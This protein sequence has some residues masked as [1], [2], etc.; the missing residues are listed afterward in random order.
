MIL[1]LDEVDL[2]SDRERNKDLLYLLS[3]SEKQYMLILLSNNPGFFEKI[4]ASA[5]SS[6]QLERVFFRNY[7][8]LEIADILRMRCEEAGCRSREDELVQ[9]ASLTYKDD[10]GDVRVALK[11]LLYLLMG[12]YPSVQKCFG[13]ARRDLYSDL[14]EDQSDAVLMILKAATDSR[15][16]LVKPVYAYYRQLCERHR[17]APYSYMHFYNHL[18]YLQSIG[19]LV[20]V[21]TRVHRGTSNSIELL[22]EQAILERVFQ[23][24]IGTDS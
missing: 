23:R 2:L 5:R 6:L 12:R 19:L 24:R 4:D 22:F 13:A 20:L 15:E 1:L 10:H 8:A 21:A 9:I 7:N 11:A 3:R 16:K 14:V 18:S 17:E